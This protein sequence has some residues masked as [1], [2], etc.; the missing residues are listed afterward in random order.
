MESIIE[1]QSPIIQAILRTRPFMITDQEGK[2]VF[3]NNAAVARLGSNPELCGEISKINCDC[4]DIILPISTDI[5]QYE[6]ACTIR[7]IENSGYVVM[8]NDKPKPVRTGSETIHQVRNGIAIMHALLDIEISSAP[9]NEVNRLMVSQ[10]RIKAM[11][12]V[13]DIT[14]ASPDDDVDAVILITAIMNSSQSS[15]MRRQQVKAPAG[16][17]IKIPSK[18]AL[19]LGL[20]SAEIAI[21]IAKNSDELIT[22]TNTEN[23]IT[24]TSPSNLPEM[25]ELSKN[26]ISG[27]LGKN[28]N[29]KYVIEYG[30]EFKVEITLELS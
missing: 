15:F 26:I 17:T 30:D 1:L 8:L 25:P 11:A 20:V 22:V 13:Y 21:H 28:L 4:D 23:T 6:E 10:A 3:C 9:D 7:I 14:Y 18:K 29:G 2:V 27:Y 12:D 16:S 5:Q 19:Y 24:I